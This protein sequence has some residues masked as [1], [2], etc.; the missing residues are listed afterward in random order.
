MQTSVPIEPYQ[1]CLF[2]NGTKIM[3]PVF[4]CNRLP[5]QVIGRLIIRVLRPC[6]HYVKTRAFKRFNQTHLALSSTYSSHLQDKS[7]GNVTD[8]LWRL[9]GEL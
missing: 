8:R 2:I 9:F 5:E 7:I 1:L 6:K 4:P 3:D